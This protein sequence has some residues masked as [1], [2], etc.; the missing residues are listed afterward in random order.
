M[1]RRRFLSAFL[2]TAAGAAIAHTLDLDKL[3][4]VAG[5]K[6]FFL[7]TVAAPFDPFFM[8]EFVS[9]SAWSQIFNERFGSVG[10]G[11]I[12]T[13]LKCSESS[14]DKYHNALLDNCR[15]PLTRD[16]FPMDY[17]FKGV[18]ISGDRV[19]I[20]GTYGAIVRS[21]KPIWNPRA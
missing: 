13:R 4:W 20:A 19:R 16:G 3:L 2:Q 11:N 15:M 21:D 10:L 8:P 6:T 18:P 12:P 1:N 7:P 9:L 14:I 5:E 17:Q